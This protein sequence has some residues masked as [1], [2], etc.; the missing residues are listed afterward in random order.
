MTIQEI[1]QK[2]REAQDAISALQSSHA[3]LLGK[4]VDM[5][6]DFQVPPTAAN[7]EPVTGDSPTEKVPAVNLP[8]PQAYSGEHSA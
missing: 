4:Y 2:L 7:T 8:P 1:I 3:A 6:A 5:S